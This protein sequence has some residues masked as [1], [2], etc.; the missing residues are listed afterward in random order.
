M[1]EHKKPEN[2]EVRDM[3]CFHVVNLSLS[4]I[5]IGS[6]FLSFPIS[7]VSFIGPLAACATRGSFRGRSSA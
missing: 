5:S 4:V 2:N 6:D 1:A 3:V 7:V